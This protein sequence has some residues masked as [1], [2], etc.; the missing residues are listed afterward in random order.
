MGGGN[1]RVELV[2][3]L[4]AA[5]GQPSLDAVAPLL[6]ELLSEDVELVVPGPAGLGAAGTWRGADDVRECLRRLREGQQN[7][8]LQILSFVSDERHVVVRLQ[9][10]A[11][12]LATGKV[13]ES[14]IIHFF[15]FAGDR[16]SRLVDFF[17]TA[18]LQRAH[19]P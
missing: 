8:D 14:E 11:R 1:S 16:I 4:Y 3:R 12:V 9:V 7:L 13:F 15:E 2:K 17:D 6:A 5:M 18:A 19:E 10:R